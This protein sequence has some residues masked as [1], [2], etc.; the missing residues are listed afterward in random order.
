MSQRSAN[1][2]VDLLDILEQTPRTI[3][4]KL[5]DNRVRRL[6]L[7]YKD[8]TDILFFVPHGVYV[9]QWLHRKLIVPDEKKPNPHTN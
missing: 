5:R 7:Y 6:P 3:L 2:L 1:I 4:V 9:P 8:G